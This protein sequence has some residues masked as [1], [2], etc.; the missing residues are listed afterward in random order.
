MSIG[1][2]IP[3]IQND[4]SRVCASSNHIPR[5][6]PSDSLP[7]SPNLRDAGVSATSTMNVAPSMVTATSRSPEP[8][9]GVAVAGIVGVGVAAIVGVGV[10]GVGVAGAVGV[11][12]GGIVGVGIGGI[13]GVAV[14]DAVGVGVAGAVGVG[15][16]DPVG[17]AVARAVGV[18][19]TDSTLGVG[20]A[21][22]TEGGVGV[23]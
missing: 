6:A 12:I 1:M 17:V 10:A 22:G 20:E 21:V 19:V 9:V 16:K 23:G 2:R 5:S 15:V 11:G 18:G 7:P 8:T 14:A 13:V 4:A 3:R